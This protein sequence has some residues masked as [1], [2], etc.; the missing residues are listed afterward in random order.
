MRRCCADSRHAEEAHDGGVDVARRGRRL[1]LRRCIST[2]TKEVDVSTETTMRAMDAGR[3]KAMEIL[4]FRDRQLEIRA[5]APAAGGPARLL[6]G[7][8]EVGDD[9]SA[10][11]LIAEGDSW[12]DY[13]MHDVLR[14]LEDNYRYDVESL[15]NAGDRIEDMAYEEGHLE[16]TTRRIEKVLRRGTAPLAILISGGGNDLVGNGFGLLLNHSRSA[17]AGPSDSIL[18]GLIDERLRDAYVYLISQVSTVCEARLGRTIPIV[19][20]GYDYPVPDGRGFLGGWSFLPGPWLGPGFRQK[21]FEELSERT[22]LAGVVI[23]RFNQM[24]EELV[25]VPGLEHVTYLDLRGSLRVDNDYRTDW[26]NEM[27]PT[28]SGFETLTAR[29]VDVLQAL[30]G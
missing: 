30:P 13:P 23:D 7:S 11:T 15:A 28:G 6:V 17:I 3:A 12:F 25:A 1:R 2:P 21:S 22:A 16:E 24:L 10:G 27:H 8:Q 9:A 18:A 29:F 20:H 4:A 14:Y 26:G 19:V 5:R